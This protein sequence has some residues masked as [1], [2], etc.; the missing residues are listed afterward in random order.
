M[1]L[2][3][4]G[5]DVTIVNVA[6]PSIR[7][8]LGASVSGLQ[9]VIDAYTLVIA[10]L[11]MFSGSMADRVGRRRV[12]QLGLALFTL[13]SALCSLA[14]SLGWLVAFR[15]VQAAGASALN[16]VA[17]S[18]IT[19]AI[20]EPRRRARALGI[21][22]GVV[23]ISLALGPVLGGVL[24]AGIGWRSVFWINIPIGLAAIAL[25]QAFVPE[26]RAA[27]PRRVDLPGQALM[28]AFIGSL[29]AAIIEGRNLG[30][31]SA[32]ILLLF[33][34]ALASL[35][36]FVAVE[37]RR[38]EPLVE[39]RFFRSAPFSGAN[40]IAVCA[41]A[42]L[43]GFLFLNSLYLQEVRGES[44][45]DTGLLLLPTAVGIGVFAPVSGR[46]LAARGPRLPLVLAG[47]GICLSGALLVAL[48]SDAPLAELLPC[49]LVF[50]VGFGLVNVPISNTAVS[51]MP[52]GQTGVAAAVASTSRQVG[53]ALGVAVTGSLI[54]V[55]GAP[56]GSAGDR[57][58]SVLALAGVLVVAFGLASTGRWARATVASTGLAEAT[59]MEEDVVAAR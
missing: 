26:S 1:S 27:H 30:W 37:R 46:L 16:P 23:G 35:A 8:D 51:G 5:I 55:T 40:L 57:A 38:F 31:T 42:A 9:W 41:F 45:L 33:A 39:L 29:T 19:N 21:W 6:L 7:A 56:V 50:G 53:S 28:M 10:S 25:T 17:L 32:P 14:P 43:G 12:F 3:I 20:T 36:G 13:G 54:A 18:I 2:L 48:P 15:V 47:V 24:I 34:A 44:A 49:Y 4:V 58:W 59:R 22:G 11:L 52:P